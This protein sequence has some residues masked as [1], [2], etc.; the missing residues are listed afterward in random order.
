MVIRRRIVLATVLVVLFAVGWLAGRGSARAGDLY[1]N[2]DVFVEIL[3]RV[4][5]NYVDP[6][7]PEKLITGAMKGMLR[8]LDPYSQYLDVTSYQNLQA[9]THGSFGGI[10]VEVSI[11]DDYPTVISPIEGGPAWTLGI[12]SGDV[13]TR[14]EGR[15]AAG[16]SID[17]VAQKLRGP[18]GTHV[19][20]GI[21]REGEEGE[22]EYSIERREIVTRSVRHAFLV[23]GKVGYVRLANFS[24]TS[25]GELRV[26]LDRLKAEGAN[27]LVLDLRSNPGG[28]LDQAVDVA[29]QFVKQG[30]R[31]VSTRGRARGQDNLYFASETRPLL[32]WPMVVLVDGASAS[33]SEIVAGSLQ[34][35]DRA[36]VVGQ[37]TFG[38]GSVQSVF[39]LR[40]RTVALK[41]TTARYYTPSGRSIH[42]GAPE[43]SP[44]AAAIVDGEE[45]EIVPSPAKADTARPSFRTPSGRTVFGGGGIRP[46]I[47][48]ARDSLPPLTNRVEG[49][50]LAFRFAN[51]WMNTHKTWKA[52]DALTPELWQDFAA[53]LAA[54]KVPFTEAELATERPLLDRA[55]RRELARRTGGDGAAIRVALEGDPVFERALQVLSR[56]RTPREVF[57]VAGVSGTPRRAGAPGREPANVR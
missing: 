12:R 50:G 47:E 34:D 19:Q 20:I 2:L 44:H 48:V 9:A 25:G 38:K 45:S 29:E 36:L 57:A 37:T 15:S 40:E 35:L 11:R 54:E 10:G 39:P 28:L 7:E 4:Q 13:I 8:D 56:A 51:R 53:F 16:L 21:R 43:V 55:V 49:R 42:R 22:V 31:I 6:V 52:S 33:A 46:D 3:Q 30:T 23:E 14:I 26:A 32:E 27:R 1:Q 24:E 18:Q 17:E 5:E 41:L